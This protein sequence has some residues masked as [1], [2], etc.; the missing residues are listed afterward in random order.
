[1]G[2][3]EAVVE[4]VR[5][6]AQRK[7][8]SRW[9]KAQ[10]MLELQNYLRGVQRAYSTRDLASLTGVSQSTISGQLT[11]AQALSEQALRAVGVSPEDIA[12][13]SQGELLRI[14]KLPTYLRRGPLRQAARSRSAEVQALTALVSHRKPGLREQKRAAAYQ[15]MRDEGR[16]LLEIPEPVGGL[17]RAQAADYLDDVLP[18]VANVAEVVMERPD[19]YYIAVTGN[20]GILVYLG[21]RER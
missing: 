18:A 16:F 6:R 21:A 15:R 7:D 4:G 3:F 2:L 17:S 9:Q 1:M 14:A 19:S 20:G 11:V 13:L 12:D 8:L 10:E 5:E